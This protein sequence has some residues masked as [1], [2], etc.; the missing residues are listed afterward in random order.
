MSNAAGSVLEAY[1]YDAIG[2]LTLKGAIAQTY[3]AGGR[4]HALATSGGQT[5]G[6]DPNGNVTSIGTSTT[7]E[8]NAENMPRRVTSGGIVADKSYVG[9]TLW[10]KVEQGVTTYYLPSIRIENGAARKYYGRYA[11]R[12]E[13]PGDAQLRFYHPDHLGS[14]SVMTDQTGA[15]IRR[16]S[17][18]PWGTDRG[19]EA[20]FTPKLQFNFKEK[21]ASGFY[22]YG[23]RLY[24]PVTGRWLSPDN[25]L[26]DGSN[27]YSYARNNPSSRVDP[28]GHTSAYIWIYFGEYISL[29]PASEALPRGWYQ[30]QSNGR[31]RNGAYYLSI[32][33]GKL[34]RLYANGTIARE[35]D[36][37]SLT[38]QD[39]RAIFGHPDDP[40][41]REQLERVSN[42]APQVGADVEA[43]LQIGEIFREFDHAK[44]FLIFMKLSIEGALNIRQF[45]AKEGSDLIQLG[46]EGAPSFDTNATTVLGSLDATRDYTS[47]HGG[48][49]L[50]WNRWSP[51]VNK[52]YMYGVLN[53][54][55][56]QALVL[57]GGG[58]ITRWEQ[59][60]LEAA[61]WRA[62]PTPNGILYERV[63]GSIIP[64]VL[65]KFP[66][67]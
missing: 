11:E 28:N 7:I 17:Y 60:V 64:P 40:T 9:E 37:G 52:D 6:Y 57:P 25:T 23:A 26:A 4:P 47:K 55:S 44:R 5:Y 41:A 14:S 67:R 32:L 1:T 59:A 13:A 12:L 15:V 58:A 48:N 34:S 21:D 24:N 18:F 42:P 53:S 56:G 61:K 50:E 8:W 45:V 33:D 65:P 54:S 35:N 31:D 30:V 16:V 46:I 2:N 29:W 20:S 49:R 36:N 19:V 27:R 62:T 51:E 43:A 63:P 39:A 22:D 38:W 66:G 10:K 3:G